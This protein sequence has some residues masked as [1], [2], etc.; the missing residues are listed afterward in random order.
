MNPDE[1]DS[2]IASL[3]QRVT[4]I[5][6]KKDG[7]FWKEA[8]A[9]VRNIGSDFKETRYPTGHAH[10]AAWAKF[11]Q[12]VDGMKAQREQ[13][14]N[15][16]AQRAEASTSVRREIDSLARMADPSAGAFEDFLLTI[17]GIKPML[18][19]G[20]GTLESVGMLKSKEWFQE[21]RDELEKL[22]QALKRAWEFFENKKERLLPSDRAACFEMLKKISDHIQC[23]WTKWKEISAS[24]RQAKA[25]QY[26]SREAEFER[27]RSLKRRL[28]GEM[29]ALDP[30]EKSAAN[31]AKALAARWKQVG[32]AGRDHEDGLWA[33]FKA[34]NDSFWN[35]RREDAAG[36]LSSA[37]EKTRDFRSNLVES[38]ER[39][40]ANLERFR[41]QRDSA[42]SDSYRDKMEAI[43]A[44][45]EAKLESK[46]EKLREVNSS[47][48]EMERRRND[49]R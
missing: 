21:R 16:N 29:R 46:S 2:A 25:A 37:I 36:R 47:I 33:D 40:C 18:D 17:S 41:S 5:F 13:H 1:L 22:S 12:I 38:V 6:G 23:E 35:R 8:W 45:I 9:D 20:R 43:I 48:E 27:K 10:Q 42:R 49:M 34:A 39:N 44:D 24:T 31:E 30:S 3:G 15:Q 11:Q 7:L 28:I 14:N 4:A 19:I 32:F 26:Q